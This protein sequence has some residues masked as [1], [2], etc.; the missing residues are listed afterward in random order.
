MNDNFLL[1]LSLRR[2]R[3]LLAHPQQICGQKRRVHTDLHKNISHFGPHQE[4]HGRVLWWIT[5]KAD[6]WLY[7][8]L[9]NKR[10]N[11]KPLKLSRPLPYDDVPGDKEKGVE[12]VDKLGEEVP[13]GKGKDT[14]RVGGI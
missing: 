13:P 10:Q 4:S 8:F 7:F 2:D 1:H 3:M 5:C 11:I 6:T 12:E 14:Q 9:I